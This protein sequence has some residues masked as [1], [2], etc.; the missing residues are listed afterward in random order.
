MKYTNS[1]VLTRLEN[2]TLRKMNRDVWYTARELGVAARVL[3]SLYRKGC[4]DRATQ[5]RT[6]YTYPVYLFRKIVKW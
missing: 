2:N 6:L 5:Y 4:V 3:H 1:E